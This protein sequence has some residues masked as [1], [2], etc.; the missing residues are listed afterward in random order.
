MTK[1]NNSDYSKAISLR[2]KTILSLSGLEISGFAELTNISESHLY[3][4]INGTRKLTRYSANK[5]AQR[6]NIKVSQLLNPKFEITSE[7]G[8]SKLLAKFYDEYK[9]VPGF[10]QK[11]R[12]ERKKSHYIESELL[13][14][15]F[16]DSPV[17]VSDVKAAC[18]EAGKKYNSKQ[19][20]QILNYLVST[21]KLEKGKMP[22]KL[23]SAKSGTRI[24]SVFSHQ[25]EK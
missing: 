21:K 4:I 19:I 6:F 22:V 3:A 2:I 17:S 5:I 16:F 9:L 23:K 13:K 24:I 15:H 14:N 11:T 7:I 25:P 8:N 18:D 20:S 12:N 1:K 10:F